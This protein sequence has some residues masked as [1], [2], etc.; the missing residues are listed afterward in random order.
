MIKLPSKIKLKRILLII[1]QLSYRDRVAVL[2]ELEQETWA[3]K[4]DQAVSKMRG[5][6]DKPISDLEINQIAEEVR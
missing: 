1:K 4:L 3:R 5:R 2:H 6:L